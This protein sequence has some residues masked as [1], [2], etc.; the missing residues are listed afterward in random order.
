MALFE[1]KADYKLGIAS[2]DRQHR[3][4]V[5]MINALDDGL[6]TQGRYSDAILRRIFVELITQPA[7]LT[8]KKA[9]LNCMAIPTMKP[10]S[11]NT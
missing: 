2:I 8:T 1:W 3:R 6:N 4:L 9:C 11:K 7:T 5:A 10:T